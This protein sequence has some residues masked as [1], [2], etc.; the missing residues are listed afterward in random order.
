MFTVE[1]QNGK[2]YLRRKFYVFLRVLYAEN[3]AGF[4]SCEVHFYCKVCVRRVVLWNIQ[5]L[6]YLR[7]DMKEF[8]IV[9]LY[10]RS[11]LSGS[12]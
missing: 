11:P 4:Y 5:I 6:C 3:I 8:G 12:P 2:S 10:F 1:R 9:L 7:C